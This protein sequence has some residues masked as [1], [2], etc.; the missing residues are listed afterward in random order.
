MQ[1]ISRSITS[2]TLLMTIWK[3]K[4]IQKYLKSLNNFERLQTHGNQNKWSI[5]I[6]MLLN[7]Y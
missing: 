3:P 2:G 5:P 1:T 4:I 6:T 7:G